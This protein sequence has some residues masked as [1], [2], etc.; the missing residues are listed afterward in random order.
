V[1]LVTVLRNLKAMSGKHHILVA[2][3][4]VYDVSGGLRDSLNLALE[5][6]ITA[7]TGN[8]TSLYQVPAHMP[9]IFYD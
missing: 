4:I 3:S 7:P 1:G 9:A 5:R 8:L 2:I 6:Q